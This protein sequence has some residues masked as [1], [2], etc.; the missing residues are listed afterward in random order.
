MPKMATLYERKS[1]LS[2]RQ[3]DRLLEL[4]VASSTGRVAAELIRLQVNM[5]AEFFLFSEATRDNDN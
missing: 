3:Q 5:A 1:K 4:F 2:V